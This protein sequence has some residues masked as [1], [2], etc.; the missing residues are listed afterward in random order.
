MVI[1]TLNRQNANIFYEMMLDKKP[2]LYDIK[3]NYMKIDLSDIEIKQIG[4]NEVELLT[5]YRMAYLTELQGEQTLEYQSNLSKE[6]NA[7][8]EQALADQRFFAFMAVYK[9]EIISFGAMVVKKIPG[10]FNKPFYL[11]GDILNMYT[12]PSARRNGVSALILERLIDEAHNRG[13]SKI[14]LHTTKEGE[15]LYRKF[16]FC[17]P[18]YPVL[19]LIPSVGN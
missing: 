4:A 9:E 19:E 6:L 11:E 7:F 18:I 1:I 14:S 15:K 5:K 8:F 2:Y 12:I 13:I 10:D 3:L 16:G 17:E